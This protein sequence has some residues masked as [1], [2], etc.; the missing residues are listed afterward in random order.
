MVRPVRCL[1]HEHLGQGNPGTLPARGPSPGR[2]IGGRTIKRRSGAGGTL[3]DSF[4]QPIAGY[5]S[6]LPLFISE[7]T[8]PEKLASIYQSDYLAFAYSQLANYAGPLCLFGISLDDT[9]SHL[10]AAIQR[11]PT[12]QIAIS[13]RP[14]IPANVI[15]TKAKYRKDFPLATLYFFDSTTHP[16]GAASLLI[17]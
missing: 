13:V 12:R 15:S 8:A 9:D 10:R 11:T 14:D 16:L 7:G 1:K 17:P 3:L 5:P 6:A 4:G 2:T